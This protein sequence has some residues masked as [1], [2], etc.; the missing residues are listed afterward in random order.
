MHSSQLPVCNGSG[1]RKCDSTP[2]VFPSDVKPSWEAVPFGEMMSDIPSVGSG[3][4]DN[5]PLDMDVVL[6]YDP[7]NSREHVYYHPRT[8]EVKV[9]ARDLYFSDLSALFGAKVSGIEHM[10]DASGRHVRSF[11]Y[12]MVIGDSLVYRCFDRRSPSTRWKK[13]TEASV[14]ATDYEMISTTVSR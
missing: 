11:L 14:S 13:E 9:S 7:R 3:Y 1:D 4:R 12:E 2:V 6:H 8:G 10:K 5:N